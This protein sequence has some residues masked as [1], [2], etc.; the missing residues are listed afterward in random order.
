METI[1]IHL[2]PTEQNRL[3]KFLSSSTG[4]IT[5]MWTPLLG[6]GYVLEVEDETGDNF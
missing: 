4:E 3:L 1:S 5:L 6:C 2:N